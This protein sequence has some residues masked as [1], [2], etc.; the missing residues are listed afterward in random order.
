MSSHYTRKT[1]IT[2]TEK[3]RN[4]IR[5]MEGSFLRDK[6]VV[7][8]LIDDLER[9]LA[10]AKKTHNAP[11]VTEL[12]MKGFHALYLNVKEVYDA[13]NFYCIDNT[14]SVAENKRIAKEIN[15]HK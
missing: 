5:I 11:L 8:G 2:K 9:S 13:Q 7:G 3:L 12:M 4:A 14:I 10:Y 6:K 15:C 1:P